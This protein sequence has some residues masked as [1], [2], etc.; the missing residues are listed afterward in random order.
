MGCIYQRGRVYWIKYSREGRAYFESSGSTKHEDAKRLLRLREGDI[1]RGVPVTPRIGRMRF[2]EA[3]RDIVTEY[4][5][6]GRRTLGHL[7][8]RIERHLEPFFRGRR[9][10]SITTADVRRF[11]DQRQ[12]AGAANGEINRELA[13]LKRMFS[14]AMH[15]GKLMNRPHIPMLEENNVRTG[16]FDREQVEGR[17]PTDC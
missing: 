13:V 1:E 7:E 9:M 15:D 17:C 3:A 14:L 12:S 10:A 2:S 8:R 5:T 6:N 16:F 4:R 11:V